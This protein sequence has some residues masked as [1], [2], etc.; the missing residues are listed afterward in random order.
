MA[1]HLIHPALNALGNDECWAN[2]AH[3]DRGL[4][5]D[6]GP[7]FSAQR[8]SQT[9]DIVMGHLLT[10]LKQ[11]FAFV[12]KIIHCVGGTYHTEMILALSE[13]IGHDSLALGM[14]EICLDIYLVQVLLHEP[15]QG[16]ERLQYPRRGQPLT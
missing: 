10:Q 9:T 3:F 13:E 5:V 1:S 14:P 15:K 6:D 7:F 2:Q 8:V 4:Q 12:Q 16:H 11:N